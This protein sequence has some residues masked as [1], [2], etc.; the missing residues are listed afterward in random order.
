MRRYHAKTSER[1]NGT[2]H[3]IQHTVKLCLLEVF[4]ASF[5]FM[6]LICD[7]K[8][9]LNLRV[10]VFLLLANNFWANWALSSDYVVEIANDIV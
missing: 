1:V 6:Q 4:D 10:Y 5:R 3:K 9:I 7:G 2:P 8:S